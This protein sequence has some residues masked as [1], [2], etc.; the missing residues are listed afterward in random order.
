MA[1]VGR[2]VRTVFGGPR[3]RKTE[4]GP[5]D[6]DDSCCFDV[7]PGDHVS[8]MVDGMKK[9]INAYVVGVSDPTCF[10][11]EYAIR[12]C[13]TVVAFEDDV[14]FYEDFTRRWRFGWV[15]PRTRSE[16]LVQDMLEDDMECE[17]GWVV[18]GD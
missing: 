3:P 4:R 15:E 11:Y 2:K 9:F 13:P 18:S 14:A 10:S 7:E 17:H 8:V 16:L 5:C 6:T 12:T 1:D